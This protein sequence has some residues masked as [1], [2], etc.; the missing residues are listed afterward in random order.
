[1]R[2]PWISVRQ[3][4]VITGGAFVLLWAG[5]AAFGYVR[6]GLFVFPGPG[7]DFTFPW[8]QSSTLHA[9]DIASL[10]T[11]GGREIQIER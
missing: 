3:A 10:Y 7:Y 9:G 5:F 4:R 6:Y 11:E 8:V 2:A 1:M